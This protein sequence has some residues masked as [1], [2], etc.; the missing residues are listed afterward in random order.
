MKKLKMSIAALTIAINS[1][2]QTA[3]V[4]VSWFDPINK[5]HYSHQDIKNY[6]DTSLQEVRGGIILDEIEIININED[7]I[8]QTPQDTENGDVDSTSSVLMYDTVNQVLVSED[9][10]QAKEIHENL[11]AIVNNSEDMLSMLQQDVDSGFIENQYVG[12]YQELLQQTIKLAATVE[13][14]E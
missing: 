12:F 9:A 8:E 7:M 1:Y 13:I 6:T 4:E 3:N 11:Y 10:E 2:S 5:I 14:K